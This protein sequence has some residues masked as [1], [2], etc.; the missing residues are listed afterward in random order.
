MQ[1][2]ASTVIKKVVVFGGMVIAIAIIGAIFGFLA[3]LIG[4]QLLQDGA[5]GFGGLVGALAGM[6]IGYPIGV[7]IGIFLINRVM[8]YRGSLLFGAIGSIVGAVFLI[9]LAEPLGIND[10]PDLLWALILLLPP[11]LGTAGFHLRR[12]G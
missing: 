1:V 4:A 5:A 12:Q 2:T 3:A 9:G 7:A 10:N 11:L 6:V 8:R